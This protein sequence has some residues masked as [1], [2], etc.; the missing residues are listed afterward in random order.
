MTLQQTTAFLLVAATM[1]AFAWG[2]IRYDLVALLSLLA[3]IVLGLVPPTSAFDGFKNDVVVIIGCALIVSAAI[4]RSGIVEAVTRPLLGRLKSEALQVPALA[5]ATMLLSIVTKN[6]GALAIMMPIALQMAGRTGTSPSRLLMPMS[7]AALVGG[8]VTLVGTSTNII[9]SQIRQQAGGPPFQMFDFAPVGLS[10]S[11]VCLIYLSVAYRLLPRVRRG[12]AA[13]DAQPATG[14]YSTEVEVPD[15]WSRTKAP[16]IA[17]LRRLA[18]DRVEALMLVRGARRWAR[19]HGSVKL[20]A[21][22]ILVLEG[23]QESLEPLM[24]AANLRLAPARR[25]VAGQDAKEEVRVVEAVIGPRSPLIG[26]SARSIGL[27]QNFGVNLLGVARA[28]GRITQQ[29][30][31]AALRAGDV[32]VLQAAERSLPSALV[33]LGARP[34]AERSRGWDWCAGGCRRS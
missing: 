19:P 9:V 7:F 34:L 12:A 21:G 32:L 28:G 16:T 8:L 6:V 27:H 14:A 10:L 29:L 24:A 2:R 20:R 18:D 4:A 1:A 25:N 11:V 33:E 30:R 22:D 13:P 15:D 5:G 23:E 3:G 31:S 17:A 26:A